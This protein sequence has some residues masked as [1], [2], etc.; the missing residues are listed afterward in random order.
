MILTIHQPEHMPWLGFFNK[1]ANADLYVALDNV[2]YR[3]KY[4]QNRNK[5]P[6]INSEIW[7]NVPIKK[8]GRRTKKIKD[9]EINNDI[10]WKE[11]SKKT[12]FHNYKNSKYFEE[13]YWYFD[14]L[15]SKDWKYLADLNLDIIKNFSTFLDIET[16]I[17]TASSLG[18]EGTGEKLI[19]DI[20][21]HFNPKVYISGKS[22][23]G[24][25]GKRYEENFSKQEIKVLYQK[26]EHPEYYQFNRKNSFLPN[27]S[28]VDL[29]F[30]LG[31]KE[32]GTLIKNSKGIN[33]E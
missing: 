11:K 17:I 7:L 9:V 30:N 2:Q 32:S 5:I 4:F 15:Y 25:Q 21:N 18:I 26:F 27:M 19:F 28:V 16:K 20:C 33:Y 24:G 13:Y 29:I 6:G 31:G 22:G 10:K 1:L 23:I 8:K 3:H 12:I 14:N